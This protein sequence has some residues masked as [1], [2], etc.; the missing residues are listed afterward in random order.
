MFSLAKV[1]LLANDR[2]EE[3]KRKPDFKLI[4]DIDEIKQDMEVSPSGY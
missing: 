1:V 3:M 4:S 2:W